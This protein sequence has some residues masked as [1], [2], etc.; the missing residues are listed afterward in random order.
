MTLR[1]AISFWVEVAIDTCEY[2]CLE[3]VDDDGI[4]DDVD[5]CRFF[6]ECGFVGQGRICGCEGVPDGACDC[7]GNQSMSGCIRWSCNSDVNGNGVCDDNGIG[8]YLPIADNLMKEPHL[9][10]ARAFSRVKV[11]QRHADWDGD[12]AV[13]T[14]SNDAFCLRGCRWTDGVWDS[15]DDCVDTSTCNYANDP[16]EPCAYIDVLGICGGGCAADED[17]DGVCDDVD[18]C[19]GVID[20][21]GVCNGPG[22]T[23]VVIEDIT[24]MY[25]SVYAEQ[26]DTSLS[27]R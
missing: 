13:T 19:V 8:M 10:M 26:I 5:E 9:M 11:G 15:G 25:D 4:C 16:S 24:I 27:L 12:Y 22:P 17:A 1:Q 14:D 20:E 23:E 2:S 3:D 18:D 6:D 21:C 7:D